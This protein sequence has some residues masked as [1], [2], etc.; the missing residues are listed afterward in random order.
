MDET[1][2]AQ[3]IAAAAQSC[4]QVSQAFCVV[5]AMAAQ[6]LALFGNRSIC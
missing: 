3:A 4:R 6:R 5:F 1:R 2:T